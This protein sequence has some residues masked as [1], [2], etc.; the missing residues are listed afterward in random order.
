[1]KIAII[2]LAVAAALSCGAAAAQ[3]AARKPGLWEVQTQHSGGGMPDMAKMLA[4]MPPAQRAQV[5]QMMKE[6][7]VATGGAPSSFRYCLSPEK[8]AQE[9]MAQADPDTKC[10]NKVGSRSGGETRFSFT[11]TSKDGTKMQGEGRTFDTTPERYAMEMTSKTVREGQAMEMRMSQRGRWLGA[12][13]K[14]LKPM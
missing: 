13:C 11:C 2:S 5:E 9:P 10:D 4:E 6:R 8:A 1:M 7:G 14:G 12:D 3:G